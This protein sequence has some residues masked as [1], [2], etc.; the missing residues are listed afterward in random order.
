M[1][2]RFLAALFAATLLC[3]PSWALFNKESAGVTDHGALTG[4]SDN[5]HPQYALTVAAGQ[6]N[7][8]STP[9]W[10]FQ[11]GFNATITDN[12]TG[13]YTVAF[14]AA[15]A[16]TNYLVQVTCHITANGVC[17]PM[18]LTKTVNGFTVWTWNEAAY[19]DADIIMVEVKR[20]GN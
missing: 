16:D 13:K 15:E 12:A 1:L 20:F 10:S 8:T 11:T 5:D 14:D 17:Q 19:A 6:F 4:L 9:A 7:G 2:N 18:V 3:S